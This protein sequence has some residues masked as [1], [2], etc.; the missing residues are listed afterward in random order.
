MIISMG[1][2]YPYRIVLT[3]RL[4]SCEVLSTHPSLS[5]NLILQRLPARAST[6]NALVMKHKKKSIHDGLT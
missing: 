1:I 6:T 2:R 4:F 3:G 5:H